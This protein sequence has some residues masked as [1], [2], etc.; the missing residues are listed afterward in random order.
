[1]RVQKVQ[2]TNFQ[3]RNKTIRFAD[4]IAR[5]VNTCYP[6]ISP[7]KLLCLNSSTEYETFMENLVIET[8]CGMRFFKE[9]L[10]DNAESFYDKIKALILPVKHYK[11]GNCGESAQLSA[12][13]ARINGIKNCHITN[14]FNSEGKDFDHAV[15][16][17]NDKQPYIID[18]WLGIADYVPNMLNR[19][20]N[21]Y[22]YCFYVKPEEEV[23]FSTLTDDE[24]TDF[25]KDNFSRKQINKL[26]KIYP[27][28]FIKRGYV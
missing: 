10:Y 19:Y 18:A 6:R 1:M 7:T 20:K 14:L 2:N 12:I 4:D 28:T 5:R 23:T 3:S 9:E 17:V 13:V 24:Y 15:L 25:L 16:Y 22:N 11:I 27:D 8:V 26:K 21:E